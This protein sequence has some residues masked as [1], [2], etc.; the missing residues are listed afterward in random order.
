MKTLIVIDIQNDFI[1]GSL[2]T[3]EA[4]AIVPNAAKKIEEYKKRGDRIICTLDTHYSNYLDTQEGRKLP[5]KHC[6]YDTYGWKISKELNV[7]HYNKLDLIR[8]ST[9]GY[10]FWN[11]YLLENEDEIEI[12]GLCTDICV[13]S[14]AL[15]IKALYPNSEI[16]VDASCCAG[17]TP[18]NH[19]AALEIMKMCQINVI[20][21]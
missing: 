13:I 7:E 2:G 14:N 16:T 11:S 12:I 9:F 3:K 15:I 20:G 6:I 1:N 21:E 10:R 18:E 8:K 4:E 19:K 5:I 17:S